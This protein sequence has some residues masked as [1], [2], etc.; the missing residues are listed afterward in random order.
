LSGRRKFVFRTALAGSLLVA[1]L[2]PASSQPA[3]DAHPATFLPAAGVLPIPGED[4]SVVFRVASRDDGAA[5]DTLRAARSEKRST[6]LAMLFS[7]VLPGA[8]QFYN[9][10]YWKV[11]VVLGF[12]LYFASS[13]LDMNRRVIDNRNM[14]QITGDAKWLSQRDFYKS[15]RDAFAWYFVVLYLLNI[16]DAYVDAALSDFDVSPALSV[17]TAPSPSAVVSLKVRF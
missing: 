17:H 12:G 4:S 15:E 13:W 7:A 11:P 9:R 5:I 10:S 14:Y 3:V 2:Q 8:G 6:G 1:V 16:A